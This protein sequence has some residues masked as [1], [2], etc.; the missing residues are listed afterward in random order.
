M[1]K[2]SRRPAALPAAGLSVVAALALA[3][4]A[5]VPSAAFDWM[6]KGQELF[7]TTPAARPPAGLSEQKIAA[8]LKE[9]LR[10]GSARVVEQLGAIDG[11]SADPEVHIPL[12][13][14][15]ETVR[16][17]LGTVGMAGMLDDLELQL[18]RAAEIATPKAKALFMQS[19][20]EM[21]LDDVMA[22]Y[23]GP[24][25]SATRY[26]QSK[27]SQ[28]LAQEM[29]PIVS[30]SLAEVGAVQTYDAAM[31]Q[32]RNLPFVPD[33]KADLTGYVVDKGMD[34]IFYYLG[35]EEAAI[36]QNPAKRTTELLQT[37]FGAK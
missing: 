22:I 6:K 29:T 10:V 27:M 28:P 15:L 35:Q 36:R 37:V 25:D 19:I 12:P 17:A 24:P 26:F 7:G 4:F 32:Y 8:G 5:P 21:T 13:G 18:N 9:A 23:N 16:S 20:E 14:S 34:G 3:F 11:F 33:A 30:E 2:S 1:K 31:G